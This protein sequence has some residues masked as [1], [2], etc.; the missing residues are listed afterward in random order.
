MRRVFAVVAVLALTTGISGG[1]EQAASGE[2]ASEPVEAPRTYVVQ[3]SEF[4]L[5]SSSDPN[6]TAEDVVESFERADGNEDFDLIETIRLAAMEQHESMVQFGRRATVAVGVTSSAPGRPQMRR[7]EH[8]QIG[9]LM[10]VQVASQQDKVLLKMSYE[11]SRFKGE[12]TDDS[13]PDT[14][15]VQL[16]TTL[17]LKPGKA[18]LLGG[19][20]AESGSYLLVSVAEQSR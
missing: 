9:T 3:L 6:L 20:S 5:K 15:T 12:G 17:L 2:A 10:R 13:P 7:T 19:S 4:R 1:Q 18:M 11:A 8:M 14:V 16:D